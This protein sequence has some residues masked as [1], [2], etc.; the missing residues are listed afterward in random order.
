MSTNFV[1]CRLQDKHHTECI[2]TITIIIIITA[3]YNTSPYYLCL[4]QRGTLEKGDRRAEKGRTVQSLPDILQ[5]FHCPP[6][7]HQL[8]IR[9]DPTYKS[10]QTVLGA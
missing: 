4:V 1:D 9:R 6:T 3:D 2:I 7:D 10:N 8:F 5:L